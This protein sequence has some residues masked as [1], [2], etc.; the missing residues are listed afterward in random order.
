MYDPLIHRRQSRRLNGYDY[1]KEGLYFVTIKTGNNRKLF[2][3]ITNGIMKLNDS[4]LVAENCWLAIP[5]HF[6]H[7]TIHD[8][9]IMPDHIHGIIEII[10]NPN[11]VGAENFL[12]PPDHKPNT[13]SSK[14]IGS[15]IRGFKTGVTKWMKQN[16]NIN[17]V[18]QRNYYDHIIRNTESYQ[19]ICQYIRDNPK[20]WNR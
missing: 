13:K 6:P 18:W 16:T 3:E 9:V 20:N 5:E 19:R 1:A 2:G 15:I 4:G 14:T 11:P 10:Y 17:T 8:F 7:T 12:P